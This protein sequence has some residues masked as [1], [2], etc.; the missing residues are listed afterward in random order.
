MSIQ[1]KL[2]DA[3][4]VDAFSA[5]PPEETFAAD[6]AAEIQVRIHRRSAE[7]GITPQK[8]WKL[9]VKNIRPIVGE[10]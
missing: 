3:M 9:V 1:Q 2:S 10:K 8:L 4:E 6:L 5:L 7:L